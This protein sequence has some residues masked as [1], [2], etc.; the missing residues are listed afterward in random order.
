MTLESTAA[1]NVL[2]EEDEGQT[3]T[4]PKGKKRCGTMTFRRDGN[5]LLDQERSG[6]TK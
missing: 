5:G 2:I 6:N 3:S 4:S 1:S